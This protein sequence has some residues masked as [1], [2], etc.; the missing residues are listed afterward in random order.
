MPLMTAGSV[1]LLD[2]LKASFGAINTG[3][4]KSLADALG[5]LGTQARTGQMASGR[6]M[7]G[8]TGQAL[9]RANTM[10]S[11]G[12]ENTLGGTLGASSLQEMKAQQEHQRNLALAR[13]VGEQNSPSTLMEVLGGLGNAAQSGA[14]LYGAYKNR[15][16]VPP[17]YS[18]GSNPSLGLSSPEN[19]GFAA[20][21]KPYGF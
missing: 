4:Q 21:S 2:P 20:R 8:Y 11:Q 5:T 6:A 17:S 19:Y 12:I 7:G 9:G 1:K 18:Y 13:L 10:A 16:M 3:G 15:P 14:A